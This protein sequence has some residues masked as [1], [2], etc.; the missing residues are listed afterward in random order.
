MVGTGS[1]ILKGAQGV[2]HNP[3]DEDP[4]FSG[5]WILGVP[6]WHCTR[7]SFDTLIKDG[8]CQC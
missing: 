5:V 7:L 6:A 1:Q 4:D 2:C 3:P 8:N